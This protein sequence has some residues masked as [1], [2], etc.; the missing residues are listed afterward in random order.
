[1]ELKYDESWLECVRVKNVRFSM[2][3][4]RALRDGHFDFGRDRDGM[5]LKTA[6]LGRIGRDGIFLGLFPDF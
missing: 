2:T 1:V 6:V 3:G 5:N 4:I